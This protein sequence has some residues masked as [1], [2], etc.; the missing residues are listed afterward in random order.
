MN[1]LVTLVALAGAFA[2]VACDD[3]A[4]YEDDMS[5]TQMEAPVAP[6]A[7]DMAVPTDAVA[8]PPVTAPTD[9]TTLPPEKRSSEESVQ[10]ESET[11][12]Y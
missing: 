6:S 1:R 8:P 3:P 11:L 2:V 4:R 12:F 9:S 7:D 10:P 5:D